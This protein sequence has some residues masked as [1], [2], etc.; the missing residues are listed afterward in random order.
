LSRSNSILALDVTAVSGMV[1][2]HE[3]NGAGF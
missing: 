1:I 3:I 2:T